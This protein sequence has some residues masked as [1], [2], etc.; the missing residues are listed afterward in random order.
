MA[1]E[2]DIAKGVVQI[3][4]ANGGLC[5]FR[6][7]YREIPN[8]VKLSA[9]NTAPSVTRPG[10]PMWYQLV[11]NIKSHDQSPGNFIYEGHLTHVPGVGYRIPD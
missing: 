4:G 2:T 5:T 3:A 6:R 1:D 10:E 11:R 9:A 8:H 7:A